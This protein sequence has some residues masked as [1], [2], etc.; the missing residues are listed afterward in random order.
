[1]I[2]RPFVDAPVAALRR[3]G[4]DVL[5]IWRA[6]HLPESLL[7]DS[8]Q[9]L[10]SSQYTR[11]MGTLWR[12]S[13]DELMG[14]APVTSR[15]GTFSMMCKAIVTC[16]SLEHAL[17]RAQNFYALFARV[18]NIRL[19][20]G[21]RLSRLIIDM[22]HD[23]DPE[24]FLSESL[25]AIWHRLASWLVGQG[26]PLLK[27]GCSYAPP[28]HAE[29]YQDLFAT[30]VMFNEPETYLQF[31]TRALQLPIAQTPASLQA[32]LHHSPADFLARP[33]PHQST[34]GQLR[35]LFRQQP[36]DD[37]PSLTLA[38]DRLRISS[39]TLRRRLHD[40][41]TS[42]QQLKDERRLEEA[43]V[44]LRHHDLSIQ[45]IA[46]NLGYTE[47]STF[48][49]A[50]RKWQGMTP[51]DYREQLREADICWENNSACHFL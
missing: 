42:Y 50:F 4:V 9:S 47:A 51:G 40:E 34:T 29:L 23:Y 31:P 41:Q 12:E 18:P 14:L 1:M 49:R 45:S 36:V 10:T 15:Y 2:P 5:A 19:H 11:L 37:L 27:V 21:K 30:P 16:S 8:N 39:A 44:M 35:R 24:H 38:A 13:D 48:H 17:H 25:L 6:A 22:E 43:C 32:F 7:N 33:N 3:R 26:I 46:A 28:A 20:K